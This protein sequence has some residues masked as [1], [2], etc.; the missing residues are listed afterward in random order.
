MDCEPSEPSARQRELLQREQ[1]ILAAAAEILLQ[2][3]FLDMSML[4]IAQRSHCPRGTIYLHF[5]SREDIVVAL[6][7]QAWEKRLGL[8]QR[9]AGY[10][11]STRLRLAAMAEGF[12]FFYALYPDQ[13]SI[14]HKVSDTI[15]Q[16]AS[17]QRVAT[18]RRAEQASADLVRQLIHEAV[19][20]G[21]I[22]TPGID[23]DELLFAYCALAT[24]GFALHELS[25]PQLILNLPHAMGQFRRA[26]NILGDGYHWHPLG[27]EVDWDE[28]SADIRRRVFAEEAQLLYGRATWH[29]EL[30]QRRLA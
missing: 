18:L 25:F 30:G 2:E 24:G 10:P 4:R 7:C 5:A 13:F 17:P 8:I 9:G 27:A 1:A 23:V 26:L 3:G 28:V 14:L 16:M 12:A 11:G 6:A 19:R 29:G 15:R 22:A 20:C 21:D